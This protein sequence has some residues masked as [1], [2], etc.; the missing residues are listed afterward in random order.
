MTRPDKR[1][2]D[3]LRHIQFH[4]DYLTHPISSVKIDCGGTKVVCAISLENNIP[5]WMRAQKVTGG[6][7]TSE[8]GMLPSSTHSRMQRETTKGKPSG[9]TME[10]QRLIG[11]SFRSVVDLQLLGANTIYID[12]DVIDADGGTRTAS[13][14]GGSV[15]L[16]VAFERMVRSGQI[17]KNPMKELVAAISIGIIEGEPRT[18]LCYDEDSNAD[19]DMNVVMTE[20]GKFIEIQGTAEHNPFDADELAKMLTLA[21]K[22]MN[23]I[24]KLQRE[25]IDSVLKKVDPIRGPK[26]LNTLD[27][28]LDQVK[29]ETV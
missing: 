3:Q 11:R 26:N 25:A 22:A 23:D 7:L 6:W 17:T 2:T 15:A 10:I 18:D 29:I 5:G 14:T 20:S 19:V 12:C 9:R 8:Y 4:M 27:T 21:K 16:F 13:I 28:L 1:K 24:F